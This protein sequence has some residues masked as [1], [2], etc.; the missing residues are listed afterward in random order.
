MLDMAAWTLALG[1]LGQEDRVFKAS[2]GF[3]ESSRPTWVNPVRFCC[4]Q[5]PSQEVNRRQQKEGNSGEGVL[6]SVLEIL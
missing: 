6:S 2:L 5:P 1:R 3:V 4:K